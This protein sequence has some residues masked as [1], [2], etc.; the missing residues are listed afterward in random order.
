MIT[1]QAQYFSPHTS[2]LPYEIFKQYISSLLK[3]IR[4]PYNIYAESTNTSTFPD[5]PDQTEIHQCV[6]AV[7]FLLDF[8][9]SS[10]HSVE[11]TKVP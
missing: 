8:S 10:I 11:K 1:L 9:T 6:F 4:N 2:N 7:H 5:D 3:L